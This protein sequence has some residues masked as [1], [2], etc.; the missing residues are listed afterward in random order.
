LGCL[1]TVGQQARQ[2]LP[3]MSESLIRRNPATASVASPLQLLL[4]YARRD[5]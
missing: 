4:V 5:D 1:L 2:S 3:L